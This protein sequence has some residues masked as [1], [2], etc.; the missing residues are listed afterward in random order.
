M[1]SG[2]EPIPGGAGMTVLEREGTGRVYRGTSRMY[3]PA[4]D[5]SR[6]TG[7]PVCARVTSVAASDLRRLSERLL[8][9]LLVSLSRRR[10]LGRIATRLP[11][12]RAMVARFVAGQTLPSALEA[13]ERLR[14]AGLHTTVD[15]LGESVHSPAAA[16]EAAER[17]RRTLDAL[18][19]A[20]L[21]RNVSVKLSQVGLEIDPALCRS[22]LERVLERADALGAFVR[23]DM[24]DHTAT[25]A[26]LE[27]VRAVRVAH[28]GVGVVVQ[29]ALRRSA[30]DV[31]ALIAE[32]VRVRLCKGAYNEPASVAFH[33]RAEVDR[34]YAELMERLL[35]A[36]TYPAIA[37]H[38]ERLLRR[39][40]VI[41]R[42]NT[43]TPDRFEFQM[44]YGVRR[45]L[46]ERLVAAGWTVRVYVPYG[47][48]WYPYFMRRLAER[49]ANI[50][51]VLRSVLRERRPRSS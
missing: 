30:A 12:T 11:L 15:V 47:S 43:I 19:A 35:V 46:Q 13:M 20:G 16:V 3:D 33:D 25:D 48:E 36:G 23:I 8:R 14:R 37:T 41:A 45:D 28:S 9:A 38:D 1:S 39:A 10:F 24:E 42:R 2:P 44:L 40:V 50:A 4:D 31:D 49:P 29:A 27:L 18:A 6:A 17:Y 51:F 26:T 5:P 22:N 21:D 34:S 32:G 7:V